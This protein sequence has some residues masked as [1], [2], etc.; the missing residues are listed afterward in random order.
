MTGTWT[1]WQ[2]HKCNQPNVVFLEDKRERL[3]TCTECGSKGHIT[4]QT[5]EETQA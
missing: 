1:T 2:C 4:F 5:M 3:V